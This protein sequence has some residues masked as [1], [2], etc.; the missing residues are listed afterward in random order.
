METENGKATELVIVPPLGQPDGIVDVFR[1]LR[2]G[3][4]RRPS[5]PDSG[6]IISFVYLLL[7]NI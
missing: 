4:E 3:L 6:A 1:S 7:S 2:L 5:G